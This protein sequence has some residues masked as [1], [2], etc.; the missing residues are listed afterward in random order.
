MRRP[1]L[2]KEQYFID[3]L[4]KA[5]ENEW[6]KAYHQPLVRAASG[7]VS[8]E[9]AFARWEDPDK[10][11]FS[12]ADFLPVLE[13]ENLTY[14]LDLCMVDLVLN[15]LKN[16]AAIGLYVVPESI[17]FARSDFYQCDM[18][19]EVIKRT[20]TACINAATCWRVYPFNSRSSTSVKR[21]I[22]AFARGAF[23]TRLSNAPEN[24]T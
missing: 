13:R 8:D 12:P 20:L 2:I 19:K 22:A 18:V 1:P 5:I 21:S 10:G 3:N 24:K 16:Q 6:I 4:D 17:N 7:L 23:L 9:E 11:N 15:K 14:K